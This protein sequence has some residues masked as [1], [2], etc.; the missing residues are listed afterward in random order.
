MIVRYRHERRSRRVGGLQ[1]NVEDPLRIV[2]I[3]IAGRLVG[4]Q[5]HRVGDERPADR[6]PL[7]LAVRQPR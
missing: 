4:E 2:G 3:E 1:K 7:F 6:N 5:Q